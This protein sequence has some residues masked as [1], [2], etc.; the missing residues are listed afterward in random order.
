MRDFGA[1]E[2]RADGRN[3]YRVI[4]TDEFAQDASTFLCALSLQPCGRGPT[5]T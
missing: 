2:Q 4:R 5:L 1:I 3:Q